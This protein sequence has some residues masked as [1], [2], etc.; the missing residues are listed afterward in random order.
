MSLELWEKMTQEV[1]PFTP[2]AD[3]VH[4]KTG[5]AIGRETK[6]NTRPTK[7][8]YSVVSM[9][10]GCGGMDLGFRGGFSVFGRNY[11]QLPFDIIWA[12][13]INAAACRTYKKNLDE[14]IH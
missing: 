11:G 6:Q 14:S 1:L 13:E 5:L 8:K 10:S 12:N 2:S 4:Q 3:M 7:N 9:F